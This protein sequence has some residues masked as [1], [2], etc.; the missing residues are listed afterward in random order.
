MVETLVSVLL[1]TVRSDSTKKSYLL[2]YK[3]IQI[4]YIYRLDTKKHLMS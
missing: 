2:G 1:N 4:R 3:H